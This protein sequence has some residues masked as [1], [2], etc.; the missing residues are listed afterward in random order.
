[1]GWGGVGRGDIGSDTHTYMHAH[2]ILGPRMCRPTVVMVTLNKIAR[3][4]LFKQGKYISVL[5][6]IVA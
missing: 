2:R 3:K 6:I 5:I 1:M 4:Q